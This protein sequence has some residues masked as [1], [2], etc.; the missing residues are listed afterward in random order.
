MGVIRRG[1]DLLLLDCTVIARENDASF[2]T[3]NASLTAPLTLSSGDADGKTND[4]LSADP[5]APGGGTAS[6]VRA[7]SSAI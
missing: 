5:A 1:G 2:V 7:D 6:A 4:G 3:L